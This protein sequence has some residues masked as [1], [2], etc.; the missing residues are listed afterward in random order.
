MSD[1][2][3]LMASLLAAEVHICGAVNAGSEQ[4]QNIALL[5]RHCWR[6]VCQPSNLPE[7]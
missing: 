7:K 4:N 6:Q 5:E 3:A 2:I 1:A